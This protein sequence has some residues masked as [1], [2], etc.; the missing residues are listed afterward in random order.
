MPGLAGGQ[1]L[2][3]AGLGLA[4]G[5]LCPGQAVPGLVPVMGE[6]DG[7]RAVEWEVIFKNT[8]RALSWPLTVFD[9]RDTP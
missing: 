5:V 1:A 4:G 2:R 8:D 6:G 9:R 3:G 7:G